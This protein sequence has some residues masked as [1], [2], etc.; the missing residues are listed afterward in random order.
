MRKG[1]IPRRM[2]PFRRLSQDD[3]RQAVFGTGD[4]ACDALGISLTL[5]LSGHRSAIALAA[6]GAGV[7]ASTSMGGNEYIS[8]PESSIHRSMVMAVMTLVGALWVGVP[9]FFSISPGAMAFCAVRVVVLA[10][11]VVW[12][13]S[14]SWGW[15]SALLRVY[16]IFAGVTV[17]TALTG[18]LA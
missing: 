17:L 9:F 4:G 10:A 2:Q 15:R 8:D 12:V 14:R 11:I 1:Y 13:R 5:W 16:T 7:A 18:L 6:L 3:I